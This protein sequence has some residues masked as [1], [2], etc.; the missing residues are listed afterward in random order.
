MSS[1]SSKSKHDLS[2]WKYADLRDAINTSCDLDL[3]E[4]CREEFHRRL[5]VYHA[6]KS[7]NKKQST[8]PGQENLSSLASNDERAP[9]SILANLEDLHLSPSKSSSAMKKSSSKDFNEQRYFRIPF[10][11]PADQLR[12]GAE[13]KK[14]WWYSHF[15]GKWIARQMEIYDDKPPVLLLAGVDDMHM[16]ELSLE[17]TGLTMKHGAEILE[18][19]FEGVWNKNGGAKYLS[20]HFGQISSKYVLNLIQ[21]KNRQFP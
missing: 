17:E 18:A 12:D 14:G 6:W 5:K 10:S 3:L 8:A 20:D 15:D 21:R 2:K 13:R 11:R 16:C 4:A 7:K 9:Q 19:D 1:S